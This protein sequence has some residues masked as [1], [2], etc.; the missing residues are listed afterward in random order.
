MNWNLVWIQQERYKDLLREAEQE[1]LA[2]LVLAA[3]RQE[4]VRRSGLLS[5]A[6]SWLGCQLVRCGEWLQRHSDYG[7]RCPSDP[8]FEASRARI[9]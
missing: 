3:Q 7:V 5:Y 6:L 9:L 2:H 4:I 1:R 8:E